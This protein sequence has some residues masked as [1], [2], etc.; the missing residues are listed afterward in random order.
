VSHVVCVR[1]VKDPGN[2]RI[3]IRQA[4]VTVVTAAA[5]LGCE[6]GGNREGDVDQ[7]AGDGQGRLN[8]LSVAVHTHLPP[9]TRLPVPVEAGR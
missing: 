8:P 6:V 3:V 5:M 7:E 9:K 4:V 2:V 1:P